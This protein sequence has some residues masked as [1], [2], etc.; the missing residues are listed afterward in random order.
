[1]LRVLRGTGTGTGMGSSTHRR[2]CAV[3]A[4]FWSGSEGG[5]IERARFVMVMIIKM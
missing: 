5:V 1:M 4:Q 3:C 2:L